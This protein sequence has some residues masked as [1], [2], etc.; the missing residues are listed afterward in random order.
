MPIKP[1]RAYI[2]FNGCKICHID[3]KDN[4]LCVKC[5][6]ICNNI[7]N[8]QRHRKS[9]LSILWS[10]NEP[11]VTFFNYQKNKLRL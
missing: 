11:F 3:N 6:H 4:L 8:G 10:M 9:H 1:F 7:D 2:Y 5:I